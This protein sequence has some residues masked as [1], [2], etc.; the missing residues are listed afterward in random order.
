MPSSNKKHRHQAMY[1][2]FINL[3][4]GKSNIDP[5]SNLYNFLHRHPK[6]EI[7]ANLDKDHVIVDRDEW[8]T[9]LYYF[10]V[11][12]KDYNIFKELLTTL[13]DTK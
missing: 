12:T 1:N 8:E 13:K 11:F 6:K 4:G 10:E 5:M 2:N 9:V 7:E 3:Y